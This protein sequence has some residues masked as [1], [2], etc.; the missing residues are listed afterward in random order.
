MCSGRIDLEFILRAF[1][2]GHDGV[3][4]GACRL[5]E[6]NYVT[7]GNYDALANTLLCEKIFNHI[8]LN[9]ERLRISFMN[10]S[11]GIHLAESINAFSKKVK[12]LGPLGQGEGQ[13][14]KEMRFNLEAVRKLIPYIRLVERERLR[15]P[16]KSE[17][18]YRDFY[19]SEEMD[20]L[21][22]E[23]IVDKVAMSKITSLLR[24]NALSTGEIAEALGLTPS[25]ASRHINSS[26]KQGLVRYDEGR[27]RYALA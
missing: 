14:T 6:C 17:K 4:I 11:D 9:P 10:A 16:V 7:Q 27:K 5:G 12:E 19:A 25:E 13:D 2:N 24:D 20:R 8:G 15:V 1:S 3:F 18:A 22:K 23:L 21:F 26:S